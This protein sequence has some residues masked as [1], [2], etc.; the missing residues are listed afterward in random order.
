MTEE[1]KKLIESVEIF[2]FC[3]GRTDKGVFLEDDYVLKSEFDRVVEELTKRNNEKIYEVETYAGSY[4]DSVTL[5][6]GL[7]T[8]AIEAEKMRDAIEA[9]YQALACEIIPEWTEDSLITDDEFEKY[10]TKISFQNILKQGFTVIIIERE[11][12]PIRKLIN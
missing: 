2:R 10:M 1:V 6:E 7:Y 9:E 8:G 4:E 5:F 3:K 12:N 11:L